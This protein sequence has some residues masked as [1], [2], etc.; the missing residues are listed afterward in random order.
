MSVPCFK[1]GREQEDQGD[2]G[3]GC[4]GSLWIACDWNDM[5]NSVRREQR[6][7][8]GGQSKPWSGRVGSE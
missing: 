6:S 8:R 4:F 3:S 5:A 1:P 2:L 7:Y